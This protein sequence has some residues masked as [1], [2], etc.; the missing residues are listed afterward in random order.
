MISVTA[1]SSSLPFELLSVSIFLAALEGLL[2]LAQDEVGT[3]A[4]KVS[5][6]P[7]NN[8]CLFNR[9]LQLLGTILVDK[10]ALKL[11]FLAIILVREQEQES[12]LQIEL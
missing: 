4:S 1:S 5:A 7:N 3:V 12:M 6:P 2:L 9:F 11:G 10:T 8:N